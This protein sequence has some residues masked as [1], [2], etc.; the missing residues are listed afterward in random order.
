MC[1]A[2]TAQHSTSE[3]MQQLLNAGTGTHHST[4]TFMQKGS[5]LQ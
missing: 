2:N 4:E 5:M 3:D 1:P